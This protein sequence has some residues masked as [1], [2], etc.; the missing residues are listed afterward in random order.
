MAKKED[1]WKGTVWNGYASVEG[2]TKSN[3]RATEKLQAVISR[4]IKH[5]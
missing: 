1:K 4:S 3:D 5:F 2:K